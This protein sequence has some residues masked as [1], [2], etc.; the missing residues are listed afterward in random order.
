MDAGDR[1]VR[2]PL[3]G[4]QTTARG[5]LSRPQLLIEAEVVEGRELTSWPSV[6]KDLENAGASGSTARS[7]RTAT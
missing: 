4:D 1:V 6:R 2:A 7:S 3:R 5:D